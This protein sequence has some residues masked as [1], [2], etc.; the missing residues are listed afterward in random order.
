MNVAVARYLLLEYMPGRIGIPGFY[1]GLVGERDYWK[2]RKQCG[3]SHYQGFQGRCR[4]I[5]MQHERKRNV[6]H[7]S[8]AQFSLSI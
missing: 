8:N 6:V 4:A 5:V 3:K 7:S 1:V 2:E